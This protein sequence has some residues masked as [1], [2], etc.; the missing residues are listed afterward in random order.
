METLPIMAAAVIGV[1]LTGLTACADGGTT[2]AQQ[3]PVTRLTITFVS[4]E[5][6]QPSVWELTC[7]PAGGT[8]PDPEGACRTLAEAKEPFAAPPPN[9]ICTEIYGGPQRATVEGTWQGDGVR[10][11]FSRTNGCEIA[12]WDALRAVLEP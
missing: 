11:E 12:R 9:Q 2:Q 4:E 6:A 10:A 1:A 7:D 5:G 3:A 8:H